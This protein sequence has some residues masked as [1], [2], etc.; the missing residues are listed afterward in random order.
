MAQEEFLATAHILGG[1]HQVLKFV[2]CGQVPDTAF[3]FLNFAA[4]P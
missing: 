4:E 2:K 3:I 1:A